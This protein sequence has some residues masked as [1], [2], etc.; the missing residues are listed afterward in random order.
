MKNFIDLLLNDS[1]LFLIAI[2][3]IVLI[4]LI[5][6]C[7]ILLKK[8]YD[9][10]SNE[11]VIN[12]KTTNVLAELTELA[13]EDNQN[14]QNVE[15]TV[16]LP[17]EEVVDSLPS[18]NNN[19]M[20]LEAMLSQMEATLNEKDKAIVNFE[21]EQEAKAIISYEELK[22]A[23]NQNSNMEVKKVETLEPTIDAK[24]VS[25]SADIA[26]DN[27]NFKNT[28]FISP[29]FGKMEN[30]YDYPKIGEFEGQRTIIKN[31]S[32]Q[33]LAFDNHNKDKNEAFLDSLKQFRKNL[34]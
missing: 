2:T 1:V 28:D 6:I 19:K 22:K 17:K 5:I 23:V 10:D 3:I 30:N 16:Y 29:I 24:E 33:D 11:H 4:V 18:E 12:T 34:E 15:R 32:N 9:L 27:K 13:K 20:D 26:K 14:K 8:R 25:R 7:I 31:E 21:Q